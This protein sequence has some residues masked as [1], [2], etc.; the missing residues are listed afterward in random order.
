MQFNGYE[1]DWSKVY[2][3]TLLEAMVASVYD[4]ADLEHILNICITK[5]Q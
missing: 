1:V 4:T 3:A 2:V 5:N